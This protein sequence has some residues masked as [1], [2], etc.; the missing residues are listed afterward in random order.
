M[1]GAPGLP[2]PRK[3]VAAYAKLVHFV[4]VAAG[5]AAC[6]AAGLTPAGLSDQVAITA[7]SEGMARDNCA[8]YFR[9]GGVRIVD[10]QVAETST[11]VEAAITVSGTPAMENLN[12]LDSC[13]GEL[14][15]G[16]LNSMAV[17]ITQARPRPAEWHHK[18]V[19]E[20]WQSGW[21][22]TGDRP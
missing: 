5:L 19:F 16:R 12:L 1:M 11:V 18:F 13:T 22:I 4:L 14:M 15:A 8:K 10:R 7:I 2:E 20:R 3:A 17:A 6:D 9:I 21:R